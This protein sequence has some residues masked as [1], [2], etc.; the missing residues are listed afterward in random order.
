MIC[1]ATVNLIRYGSYSHPHPHTLVILIIIK[2]RNCH[3]MICLAAV[4]LQIWQL[5]SPS[6]SAKKSFSSIL[7]INVGRIVFQQYAIKILGLCRIVD[8]ELANLMHSI[9][10][11]FRPTFTTFQV[12]LCVWLTTRQIYEL[13]V[14]I[15][16]RKMQNSAL[17]K[18]VKTADRQLFPFESYSKNNH[19]SYSLKWTIDSEINCEIS[20][21]KLSFV[22][23]L[24]ILYLIFGSLMYTESKPS[25][26]TR[27]WVE[28]AIMVARLTPTLT[29]IILQS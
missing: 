28:I 23:G 8:L 17:Y 5:N 6:P 18:M 3:L 16:Y 14:L 19:P 29:L 25:D 1:V 26:E 13:A 7:T 9:Q 22:F 15:I 10:L 4:N 24:S 27:S 12:L 20:F 21:A 11:K 2:E